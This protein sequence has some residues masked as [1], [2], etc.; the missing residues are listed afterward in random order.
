ML[1]GQTDGHKGHKEKCK[2]QTTTPVLKSVIILL[3]QIII[4]SYYNNYCCYYYYE[5][6]MNLRFRV[7]SP[8][9]GFSA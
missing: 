6:E 7:G 2:S 3:G 9:R 5:P 4:S 8:P 1:A